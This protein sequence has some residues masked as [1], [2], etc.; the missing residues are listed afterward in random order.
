MLMVWVVVGGVEE[1]VSV[2]ATFLSRTPS[3]CTQPNTQ[4]HMKTL[5]RHP[6]AEIKCLILHV[7]LCNGP[8][9]EGGEL[10]VLPSCRSTCVIIM[11]GHKNSMCDL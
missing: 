7:I 8:V 6:G 5:H 1:V 2:I 11:C 10:A 9:G 4:K 3:S